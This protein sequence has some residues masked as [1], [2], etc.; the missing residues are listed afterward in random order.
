MISLSLPVSNCRGFD[1]KLAKET[2]ETGIFFGYI[3]RR[4]LTCRLPVTAYNLTMLHAVLLA[5][6]VASSI[7]TLLAQGSTSRYLDEYEVPF[8]TRNQ[9]LINVS[10]SFA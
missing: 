2:D 10:L 6:V 4:R 1:G 8:F 5:F 9:R 3:Y 7:A